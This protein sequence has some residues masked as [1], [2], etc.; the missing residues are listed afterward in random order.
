MCVCACVRE[1]V[2]ACMHTQTHTHT[3]PN[4]PSS[5][6]L[7]PHPFKQSVKHTYSTEKHTSPRKITHTHMHPHT[8]THTHTHTHKHH[9]DGILSEEPIRFL[10][11][12]AQVSRAIHLSQWQRSPG[13]DSGDHHKSHMA[14]TLGAARAACLPHTKLEPDGRALHQLL[15]AAY[16]LLGW[17]S[18]DETAFRKGLPPLGRDSPHLSP[19][20]SPHIHLKFPLIFTSYLPHIHSVSE[21][22]GLVFI[23]GPNCRHIQ[24]NRGGIIAQTQITVITTCKSSLDY[25]CII[26]DYTFSY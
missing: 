19:S 14:I 20:Y 16:E 11:V 5:R 9:S 23:L 18:P 7:Y 25:N 12:Q 26:S 17:M 22:L 3:R 2:R 24:T 15:Q 4:R 10:H 6:G 1:C 13:R 8:C 21:I